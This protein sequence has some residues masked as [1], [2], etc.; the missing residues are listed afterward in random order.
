MHLFLLAVTLS[1]TFASGYPALPSELFS[2]LIV[3][4]LLATAQLLPGIPTS[5]PQYTT[6]DT[7]KWLLFGADTWT[8]GFL[9]ATFYALVERAAVCPR[10]MNGTSGAQWLEIARASATGEIP[11]ET[12]TS[13][14]H[15]VGFLSFPFVEELAVCATLP[16]LS[17]GHCLRVTPP[18]TR[19]MVQRCT[20]SRHSLRPSLRALTPLLAARAVGTQRTRQCLR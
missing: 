19:T 1:F 11:L 6:R 5:Y 8:S 15:D 13:V 16:S 2:P 9:P 20:P 3:Q 14:G 10:S 7:G 4:K 17:R 18:E 12:H